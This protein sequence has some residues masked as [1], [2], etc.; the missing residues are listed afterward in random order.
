MK[1]ARFL[2]SFVKQFN[3]YLV[4]SNRQRVH[5]KNWRKRRTHERQKL[6]R[7]RGKERLRVLSAGK[8]CKQAHQ[9]ITMELMRLSRRKG[10]K[11]NMLSLEYNCKS[12]LE[13][14]LTCENCVMFVQNRKGNYF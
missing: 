3:A 6:L 9:Y 1:D 8:V 10:K 2:K 13:T 5:V 11:K 7:V 12:A 14:E 4:F